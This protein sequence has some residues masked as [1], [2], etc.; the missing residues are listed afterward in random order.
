L[1][2]TVRADRKWPEIPVGRYV[3]IMLLVSSGGGGVSCNMVV[4]TPMHIHLNRKKIC[5]QLLEQ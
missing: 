4:C 1:K 3:V 5:S 2:G